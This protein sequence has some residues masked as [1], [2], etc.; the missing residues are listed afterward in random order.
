MNNKNKIKLIS[1]KKWVF[2]YPNFNLKL[3]IEII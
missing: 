1:L 3:E 2:K